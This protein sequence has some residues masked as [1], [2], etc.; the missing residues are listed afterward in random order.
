MIDQT[1]TLPDGRTIGFSDYGKVDGAPI[2][3]SLVGARGADRALI[4]AAGKI[5]AA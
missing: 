2:G 3:I 4:A 5:F 1:L